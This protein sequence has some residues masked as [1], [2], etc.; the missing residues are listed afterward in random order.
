MQT[1]TQQQLQTVAPARRRPFPY[2]SSRHPRQPSHLSHLRHWYQCS[3]IVPYASETIGGLFVSVHSE[4]LRDQISEIALAGNLRVHAPR[5]R[6]KHRHC[7]GLC[8]SMRNVRKRCLKR[9]SC[10]QIDI[11]RT[12]STKPS[13]VCCPWAACSTYTGA[14]L[15]L[16]DKRRNVWGLPNSTACCA[17]PCARRERRTKVNAMIEQ[18]KQSNAETPSPTERPMT[19]LLL[20]ISSSLVTTRILA[21]EFGKVSDES[22]TRKAL[23]VSRVKLSKAHELVVEG[24]DAEPSAKVTTSA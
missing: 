9:A 22:L 14:V 3:L 23:S 21:V 17:V 1:H 24:M 8:K 19:T 11:S 4:P 15:T 12:R 10:K 2:C 20:S 7:N 13:R 18:M 5:D 6:C 16:A